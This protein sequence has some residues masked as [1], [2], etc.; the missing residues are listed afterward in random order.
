[1]VNQQLNLKQ[2][3]RV[4]V[5]VG[6]RGQ[7]AGTEEGIQELKV[8]NNGLLKRMEMLIEGLFY[9]ICILQFC[10]DN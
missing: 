8:I 10:L 9:Y 5:I 4:A 1:M 6:T 7:E 3:N 2:I